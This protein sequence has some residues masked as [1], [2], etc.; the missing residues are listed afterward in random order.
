MQKRQA[1][2]L[3]FRKDKTEIV[4]ERRGRAPSRFSVLKIKSKIKMRS[5]IA[6][7]HILCY[8]ISVR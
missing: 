2:P 3:V 5:D 1:C 4:K 6:H 8:T 7:P